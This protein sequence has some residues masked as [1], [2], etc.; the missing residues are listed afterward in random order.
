MVVKYEE[1]N[2]K[3]GLFLIVLTFLSACASNLPVEIKMPIEDS[4][5][6]LD[7]LQKPEVYQDEQ[8]RWG[9]SIASIKNKESETWV[10]IVSRT[11]D[12]SGRPIKDDNTSGRFIAKV[13]QF[14][15]SEIYS[16][17]RLITIYGELA[18]SQNGKIGDQ[19][20]VYPLVN[21]KTAYLWAEYREPPQ[22]LYP[23]SPYYRRGYY[24]PFWDPHWDLHWRGR[25]F[26]GNPRFEY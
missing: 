17:G 24:D 2:M 11:L 14:L 7:V 1:T 3:Q 5:L 10:E 25:Y 19:S 12:S 20:Y 22:N 15:D 8:I 9:G 18:G 13:K 16:K 26:Y 4:P 6:L 21:S 23:H